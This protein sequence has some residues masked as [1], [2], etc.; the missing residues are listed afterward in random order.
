MAAVNDTPFNVQGEIERL[1]NLAHEVCLGPSTRA[2]V[3]AVR[4]RGI[5]YRRL[6]TDSL[7]FFGHGRKQ[8]RI[9]AAETDRT[10]AI[11]EAIAQDKE[12]TRSLLRAIGVPTSHGRP[13]VSAEDAWTAAEEIGVPVV[14]KPHGCSTRACPRRRRRR[15]YDQSVGRSGE[16]RSAPQRTPRHGS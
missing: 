10:S 14:V 1:R 5:P 6:N 4:A 7:V 15:P 12:M 2:I 13:V 11:A 8:R 16:H 9:Q 3:E